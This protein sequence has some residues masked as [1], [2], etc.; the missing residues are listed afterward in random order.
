MSHTN[1]IHTHKRKRNNSRVTVYIVSK[2]E[3]VVLKD[4]H[5]VMV[6]G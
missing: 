6:I 1:M 4:A 5:L 3:F 2:L